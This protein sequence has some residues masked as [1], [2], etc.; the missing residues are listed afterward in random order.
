LKVAII[1][2]VLNAS[3]IGAGFVEVTG[4]ASITLQLGLLAIKESL[5]RKSLKSVKMLKK[6]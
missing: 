1:S 3:I 2:L 6:F 4:R 5:D